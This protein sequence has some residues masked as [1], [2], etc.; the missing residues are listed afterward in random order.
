MSPSRRRLPSGRSRPA[1]NVAEQHVA[2]EPYGSARPELFTD[3][4][5]SCVDLRQRNCCP[6]WFASMDFDST[7]QTA[8]GGTV[9]ISFRG[10]AQTPTACCVTQKQAEATAI[11][12]VSCSGVGL[13]SMTS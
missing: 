13:A 4:R 2:G 9:G 11:A 8:R 5:I 1:F 3:Y 6:K 10:T 12:S 7:S